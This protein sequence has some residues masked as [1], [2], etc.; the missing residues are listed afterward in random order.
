MKALFR[1]LLM[2]AAPAFAALFLS[3]CVY[4]PYSYGYGSTGYTTGSLLVSTSSSYWGYDPYRY[5]YYDYRSRRYYDPYL[6][7]Y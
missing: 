5:C 6:N 2:V 7:G 4:D 3:S 1:V